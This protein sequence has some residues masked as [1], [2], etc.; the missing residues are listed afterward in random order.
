MKRI[1]IRGSEKAVAAALVAMGVAW[2]ARRGIDVPEWLQI[3]VA[4]AIAG[5]LIWFTRNRAPRSS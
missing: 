5:V 1:R 2:A 3:I 4:G